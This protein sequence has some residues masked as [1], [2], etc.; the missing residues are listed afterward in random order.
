MKALGIA[1]YTLL[2]F[3]AGRF[4]DYVFGRAA[5]QRD[6]R[7]AEL[8]KRRAE[9]LDGVYKR[10]VRL[11][12]ALQSLIN[13]LQI[14][15]EPSMTDKQKVA[16]EA[17]IEFRRF[18]RENRIY[19]DEVFCKNIYDLERKFLEVWNQFLDHGESRE[20]WMG[21]WDRLEGDFSATSQEIEGKI[22]QMIGI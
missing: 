12:R 21:A 18:F 1:L 16:A 19:F 10:I 6:T 22:R 11:E 14:Q 7:F 17:G 5:Y 9:A 20:A 2:V 8:H 15:G 4:S 13:P 3:L